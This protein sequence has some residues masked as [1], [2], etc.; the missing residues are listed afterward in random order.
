MKKIVI[1]ERK[2]GQ[3][4]SDAVTNKQVEYII[5]RGLGSNRGGGWEYRISTQPLRTENGI[6]VFSRKV[7]FQKINERGNADKQWFSIL[8]ILAKSASGS[9]FGKYPWTIIQGAEALEDSIVLDPSKVTE[10]KD[11]GDIKTDR[12]NHFDH[13]F[14][15]QNQIDIVHSAIIAAKESDLNNRFHCVLF[16]PPGCGK[17]EILLGVGKMAGSEN[18]AYMK[19]DATSTTE[20]GAYRVLREA[21]HIPPILLVEEIEK[22]EEK[23]LRWLL[24]L[25]DQ[26]AEIRRTN[27]RTGNDSRNVKMLCLATVN[28]IDLFRKVMSGALASRFAHQVYCPRPNRALLQKIL[29]REVTKSKGDVAWIEPTLK[30]CCDD[31]SMQ[32]IFQDDPRKVVP[33]CLCGREKLLTGEYQKAVRATQEPSRRLEQR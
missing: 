11:Y 15:R 8:T 1:F 28:D 12:A 27:F 7:I 4:T 20:A 23:S 5:K 32:A 9:K 19:F 2:C 30:F 22:A 13:I 21:S 14:D 18:D 29:E 6:W 31:D 33:I 17:S 25:L 24:G 3:R 16:G 26:R 10:S